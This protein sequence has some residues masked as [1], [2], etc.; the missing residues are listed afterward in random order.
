M[1]EFSL[2]YNV[3]MSSPAMAILVNSN[4]VVLE[5]SK[6]VSANQKLA[7]PCWISNRFE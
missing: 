4:E 2:L 6:N 5:K 1:T 7:Q 3:V